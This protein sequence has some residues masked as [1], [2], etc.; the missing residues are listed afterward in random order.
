MPAAVVADQSM[1]HRR[2]KQNPRPFQT[3]WSGNL[4]CQTI[5]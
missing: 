3:K 4:N 1:G 2:E 5:I